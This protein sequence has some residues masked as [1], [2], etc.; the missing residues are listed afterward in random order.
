MPT[1]CD[2]RT[3]VRRE[4]ETRTFVRIVVA[5]EDRGPPWQAIGAEHV[6]HNHGADRDT[7]QAD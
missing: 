6:E 3:L 4:Q 7:D 5:S 2:A 1:M